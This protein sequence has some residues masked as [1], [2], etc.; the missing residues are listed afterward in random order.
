MASAGEE[1]G[2]STGAPPSIRGS[3]CVP[4]SVTARELITLD[5]TASAPT[6]AHT[7][8]AHRSRGEQ[9]CPHTHSPCHEREGITTYGIVRAGTSTR[10]QRN[11]PLVVSFV[12]HVAYGVGGAEAR[13]PGRVEQYKPMMD[14][15]SPHLHHTS[16]IG[17]VRS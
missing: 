7:D 3:G 8:K 1:S 5:H 15:R 6:S 13:R 12:S 14:H 2:V 11:D 17:R 10:C 9:A 16:S 4:A